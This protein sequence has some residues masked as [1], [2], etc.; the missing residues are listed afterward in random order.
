MN[1]IRLLPPRFEP[2]GFYRDGRPIFPVLGA[3]SEDEN[4]IEL[5]TEDETEIGEDGAES[6][7]GGEAEDKGRKYAPPSEAEWHRVQASL[8]KANASAKS[9]REALSA[10]QKRV[11]EL[12]DAQAE[13][14]AKAER[15]QLGGKKKTADDDDAP[16]LPDNVMTPAQV[17][18]VVAQARREAVEQTTSKFRDAAVRAAASSALS[19]AGVQSANVKRLTRL[20]D[21]DGIELDDEGEIAEGL[22]DQ[23]AA[24]K[25]ELPQL[26][27][28]AAEEP[29]P[30]AKSRPRPPRIPLAGGAPQ[31]EAAPAPKSSAQTMADAILGGGR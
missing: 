30:K 19:Q 2:I 10:A 29:A 7:D 25:E 15:A 26:F 11:Q 27:A 1:E 23:I 13:A 12:E 4:E 3:S 6:E 14:A 18:Q 8:N 16:A 31:T 22:D 24:L 21:L 28:K 20:L 5:D 9:K 17:K